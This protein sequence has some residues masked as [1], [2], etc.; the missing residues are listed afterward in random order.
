MR[1]RNP[2]PAEPTFRYRNPPPSGNGINGLG[3]EEKFRPRKVFHRAPLIGPADEPAAW[4]AL[5][6]HFNMI[7]GLGGP[8][9]GLGSVLQVTRNRWQMRLANGPVTETR[10]DVTD[11]GAMAEEIR[12]WAKTRYP[13]A[14]L[15][16]SEIG[17]E[18]VYEG[19][20]APGTYAISIALPMDRSIMVQAP[21]P[22]AGTEVLRGYRLVGGIAV[23]L[24]EH[25]RRMGWPAKGH[26]DTKAGQ[27]LH[28]P[29]AIRGGLGQLG[30]HGSMINREY[31][32]NFRLACVTTDL[33]LA[34][35]KPVDIGVDD[36]CQNC[37]RCVSDCPPGAIFETKQTVR[38]VEKWYVNFDKCVPYFAETS[39]CS[40]CIEVCPWSEPGRGPALSEKLLAKRR[41]AAA[42]QGD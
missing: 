30:K 23:E 9:F 35:D 21:Q 36:L 2:P 18:S 17:P 12:A 7:S 31:G 42:N 37:R 22:A 41:P 33:P 39:A 34:P 40:I 26:F 8:V 11:P 6:F 29:L 28:I 27:I 1:P 24:G 14:I 13:D 20:E 3:V 32:S 15:G 25:I 19:E 5:D 16:F 10:R 38:G 4:K